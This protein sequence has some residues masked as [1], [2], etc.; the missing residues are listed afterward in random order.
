M[1]ARDLVEKLDGLPLALATA[2]AYLRHV[3]TSFGDYLR[4]YTK[5]WARLHASTPDL[6]FLSRPHTLLYMANL[7]R[8]ITGK[9]RTCCSFAPMV[10]LF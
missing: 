7:I 1:D 5:S 6:G 9:K 2:G 10:G 4:L 3:A 8:A